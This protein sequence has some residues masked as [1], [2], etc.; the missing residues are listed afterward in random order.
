MLKFEFELKWFE[1]I[2]MFLKKKRL[3]FFLQGGWAE[4]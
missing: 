1:K 4:T 2:K 3:F